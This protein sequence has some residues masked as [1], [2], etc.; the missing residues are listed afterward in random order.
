MTGE[1]I[2]TKVR[3]GQTGATALEFALLFPLL[4]AILYGTITYGFAFFVQQ[5]LNFAAETGAQAGV[6]I[7]SA[8]G[9]TNNALRCATALT[10]VT[11][12]LANMTS[13]T[14]VLPTATCG[15]PSLG[16]GLNGFS[17]TVNFSFLSMLP[18]ITLP[19][20]ITVPA[21][22]DPMTAT[23]TVVD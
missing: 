2:K 13:S 11:T 3:C 21:L 19:G 14:T 8:N 7:L 10:A 23:A 22:P 16:N 15:N 12:A 5:Q 1:S 18:S 6:A 17:V 4:F 20:G 9:Q